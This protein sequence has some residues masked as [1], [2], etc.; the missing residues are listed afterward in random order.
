MGASTIFVAAFSTAALLVSSSVVAQTNPYNGN[1]HAA[2]KN[3]KGIDRDGTV[4]I[5]NDAGSWD[6]NTQNRNNP[7]MGRKFPIVVQT[8]SADELTFLV[9]GSKALAGCPDTPITFKPVDPTTLKGTANETEFTLT[10]K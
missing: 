6:M 1:W 7:C 9:N 10:R 8:A 2:F 4:V 3:N 5:A